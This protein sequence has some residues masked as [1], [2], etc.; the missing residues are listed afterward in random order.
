MWLWWRWWWWLWY[1]DERRV[2]GGN[3]RDYACYFV[4]VSGREGLLETLE[5]ES[6]HLVWQSL[7]LLG[8]SKLE[9][10]GLFWLLMLLEVV[11][12]LLLGLYWGSFGMLLLGFLS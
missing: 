9:L 11:R 1:E 4:V 12:V 10:F 3:E 7:G 6:R 2:L 5:E 8:W